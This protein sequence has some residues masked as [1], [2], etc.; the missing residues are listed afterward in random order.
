[1]SL[2]G[3]KIDSTERGPEQIR[4]SVANIIRRVRV[5]ETGATYYPAILN[6]SAFAKG[7]RKY[8]ALGGGVKMTKSGGESLKAIGAEFGPQESEEHDDARFIISANKF[9]EAFDTFAKLQ[10]DTF[11]SD[12]IREIREELSQEKLAGMESVLTK[13]EVD[14]IEA[15]YVG[16]VC[17]LPNSSETSER[18]GSIPTRRLFHLFEIVV[19]AVIFER[20]QQSEVLKLFSEEELKNI[21]TQHAQNRKTLWKMKDAQGTAIISDNIFPPDFVSGREIE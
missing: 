18:V 6:P 9:Q 12:P 13:D 14:E 2:E 11:E 7:E 1:M 19:P 16:A 20:M 15:E 17:Q 8:Q 4:I 21:A 10:P 3:R 5:K